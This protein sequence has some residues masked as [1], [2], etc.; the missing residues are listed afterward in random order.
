MIA[1]WTSASRVSIIDHLDSIVERWWV[2]VGGYQICYKLLSI[3]QSTLDYLTF[4][5]SN[6]CEIEQVVP[7]RYY[8]FWAI[9]ILKH[10]LNVFP[11][12]W[13][14]L[15][16]EHSFFFIVVLKF[17]EPQS[18]TS[19]VSNIE[20][21]LSYLT[22][23]RVSKLMKL[24]KNSHSAYKNLVKKRKDLFRAQTFCIYKLSEVVIVGKYKNFILK[25]L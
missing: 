1:F 24:E 4:K 20:T 7:G 11:I 9:R 25:A 13:K 18:Y 16:S 17:R 2:G 19:N 23:E 22:L 10:S 3:A 15:K 21:V 8:L 5:S 12:F 6:T 14:T